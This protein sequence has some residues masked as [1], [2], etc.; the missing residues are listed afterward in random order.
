MTFEP[1]WPYLGLYSAIF[2]AKKKHGSK[3]PKLEPKLAKNAP[4]RGKN[5]SFRGTNLNSVKWSLDMLPTQPVTITKGSFRRWSV[6]MKGGD[7]KGR[8]ETSTA[9]KL[10]VAHPQPKRTRQEGN[11]KQSKKQKKTYGMRLCCRKRWLCCR[12]WMGKDSHHSMQA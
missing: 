6:R 11:E 4:K 2:G 7:T 1:F 12:L 8:R 10:V 3:W 9:K 5:F